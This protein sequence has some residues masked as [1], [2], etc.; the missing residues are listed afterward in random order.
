M[1]FVQKCVGEMKR[2]LI[3]K[4]ERLC[5]FGLCVSLLVTSHIRI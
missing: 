5:G 3:T 2:P 4:V 1:G